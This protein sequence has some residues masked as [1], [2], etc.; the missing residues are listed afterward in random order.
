MSLHATA[1]T[2]SG[3]QADKLKL[4]KVAPP[5]PRQQKRKAENQENEGTVYAN[6]WNGCV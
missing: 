6:N 5:P 4:K 2:A 3:T 1:K